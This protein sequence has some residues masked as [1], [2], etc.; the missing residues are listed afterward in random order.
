[1]CLPLNIRER[2]PE[3]PARQM[4]P[5][6]AESR[7][8]LARDPFHPDNRDMYCRKQLRYAAKP[9]EKKVT[10]VV[11]VRDN[12]LGGS[13][14]LP[15]KC[16]DGLEYPLA[17]QDRHRHVYGKK[18]YASRDVNPLNAKAPS[19]LVKGVLSNH[20]NYPKKN[21]ES[22]PTTTTGAGASR[23]RRNAKRRSAKRKSSRSG[24][25]TRSRRSC[26]TAS[27]QQTLGRHPSTAPRS[28]GA[29]TTAGSCRRWKNRKRKGRRRRKPLLIRRC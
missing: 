11:T 4:I 2:A 1:M 16:F 7:K 25:A 3:P 19:S 14:I 27:L 20:Q 29:R 21:V 28:S 10:H 5:N 6:K 23:R 8:A 17:N 13:I 15:D 24:R 22:S 9:R 26:S 12:F 18:K